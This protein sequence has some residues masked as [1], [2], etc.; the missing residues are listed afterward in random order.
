MCQPWAY[1][2]YN[3]HPLSASVCLCVCECAN[4]EL[5]HPT[6]LTRCLLLCVFVSV[7]VPTL[8]L[9]TLQHSPVVCF[10][11]FVCLWMCQPWANPPYN[12]SPVQART[13]KLGQQLQN[14]LVMTP[15][16]YIDVIMTTTAS[17]ITSLTVVYSTVYSDADQRK[18]QRSAS[19]AFVWGIHRD[20]WIP[21]TK[22]QLR[23]KCFHLMT[24]SCVLGV[25]WPWLSM[26]NFNFKVQMLLHLV[27]SPE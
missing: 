1:P 8:S 22:G 6:T 26:S 9:S 15:F 2:P 19:L 5:I 14:T 20:R 24:S 27:C 13:N 12:S 3:S 16:H 17:Q 18:H 21:R 11:V 23:G 25:D 10:C 7:N 4:P